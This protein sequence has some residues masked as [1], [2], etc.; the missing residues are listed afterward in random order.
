MDVISICLNLCSVFPGCEISRSEKEII[1]EIK[2]LVNKGIT[3]FTLCGQNVNSWGLSNEEKFRLRSGGKNGD[4]NLNS[5][6]LPFARL[7][8]KVHAIKGVEKIDFISSNP[9]D[10]TKDLVKF[11]NSLKFQIMFMIAV[12]PEITIF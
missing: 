12:R 5:E 8:K 11:S 1:E 9:F 2:C 4:K 6:G 7:I 10:F 3:D